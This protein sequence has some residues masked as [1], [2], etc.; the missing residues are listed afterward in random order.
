MKYFL[1]AE[2][3]DATGTFKGR[4]LGEVNLTCKVEESGHI[5]DVAAVRRLRK[6]FNIGAAERLFAFSSKE[7]HT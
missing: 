5:C 4:R 7:R 1:Y 6:Q 3:R 2:P